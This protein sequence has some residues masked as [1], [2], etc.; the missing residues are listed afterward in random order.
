LVEHIKGMMMVRKEYERA[1]RNV[2]E[3]H[4]ILRAKLDAKHRHPRLIF[5]VDGQERFFVFPGSASDHRSVKN[6]ISQLRRLLTT[7]PA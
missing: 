1:L 4:G 5:E 6:S 2:L 3:A 7:I